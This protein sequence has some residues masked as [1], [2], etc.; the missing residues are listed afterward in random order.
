MSTAIVD[1][2][3]YEKVLSYLESECHNDAVLSAWLTN[4]QC[5]TLF[6]EPRIISI[7]VRLV[8]TVVAAAYQQR[9]Q[10]S[11]QTV[12]HAA[13]Q[14][15][16]LIQSTLASSQRHEPLRWP[17]WH[18]TLTMAIDPL[19]VHWF[20]TWYNSQQAVLRGLTDASWYTVSTTCRLIGQILT[21]A[22]GEAT[23]TVDAWSQ[24]LAAALPQATSSTSYTLASADFLLEL[25]W[26]LLDSNS[27]RCTAF[28][29]DHR[30]LSIAAVHAWL[31]QPNRAS[32]HRLLAILRHLASLSPM[33][34]YDILF[35]EQPHQAPTLDPLGQA[36][37]LWQSLLNPYLEST[38]PANAVLALG[39]A[40]A[41]AAW[42]RFQSSPVQ[43][44]IVAQVWALCHA[45]VEAFNS[46]AIRF[47]GSS[48]PP[49]TC[50]P[51]LALNTET[52]PAADG[53]GLAGTFDPVT[54]SK[55]IRKQI[56]G[57][58]GDLVVDMTALDLDLEV[59]V[60]LTASL[61]ALLEGQQ[62][63]S[64]P[65]ISQK[66][67]VA[68]EAVSAQTLSDQALLVLDRLLLKI[69]QQPLTG[70]TTQRC[71]D[72]I[73]KSLWRGS[74]DNTEVVALL[75]AQA[76]PSKLWDS[77][78][79]I[80]DSCVWFIQRLLIPPTTKLPPGRI[81]AMR[82][83]ALDHQLVVYLFDQLGANDGYI[84]ERTLQTLDAILHG[85][86][87]SS[88]GT[89]WLLAQMQ[90]RVDA[91]QWLAWLTNTEAIVRRAAL[92]LAITLITS[93]P[94]HVLTAELHCLLT[95]D[96]LRHSIDDADH[97]V[98]VRACQLVYDLWRWL[99][100]SAPKPLPSGTVLPPTTTTARWCPYCLQLDMLL[101]QAVQDP[102][103]FV[104]LKAYESLR[105]LETALGSL[106]A[107]ELS[108]HP[109][110]RPEK[111][112]KRQIPRATQSEP[113]EHGLPDSS[114]F[115]AANQAMRQ[116][117]ERLDLDRLYE[118]TSAEHLYKEALEFDFNDDNATGQTS[119][120]ICQV[121]HQV[122]EQMDMAEQE[123]ANCG[124]NVLDC[125]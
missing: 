61:V 29:R 96:R 40:G 62:L 4:D 7:C 39:L 27:A 120:A 92:E 9:A 86:T 53:P 87:G 41:L 97:E 14:L 3:R 117:I 71:L 69:L 113:C 23:T 47:E 91:E 125:Y 115:N 79:D 72:A 5:F 18:A 49:T 38:P 100:S 98:R 63:L 106:S 119:S 33:L 10:S 11:F 31:S 50:R 82:S 84:Q 46:T 35:P 34:F 81:D 56:L 16:G 66:A 2:A 103:R 123:P 8:G 36:R 12:Q 95:F 109:V 43:S 93:A 122:D 80:R 6:D 114:R 21:T 45:V 17:C 57:Q 55:P 44:A 51:C 37:T 32:R 67:L 1:D 52:L 48:G 54:C 104:R 118:T 85:S 105:S 124:N 121:A 19:A 83:L 94:D 13:P 64:D 108:L 73:Q 76:L 68:I 110:D 65:K 107:T 111:H 26:V 89:D 74:I 59:V 99:T 60:D 78:W 88:E 20:T 101:V 70:A 24:Q 90:H 22:G 25:I 42:A 102:S 77:Q 30:L 28:L 15:L 112:A 58:V 116:R 75:F